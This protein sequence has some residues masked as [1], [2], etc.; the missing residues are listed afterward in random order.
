MQTVR[1]ALMQEGFRQVE[2][3]VGDTPT[4]SLAEEFP[5]VSEIRP[6]NFVFYDLMQWQLGSCTEQDI[7]VAVAVPVVAVYPERRQVVV[8]GGAVH[9]SKESLS[10]PHQPPIFGLAAFP[11]ETG[12]GTLR[13]DFYLQ[14]LSQEHGIVQVPEE[15]LPDIHIGDL[16]LIVPVHSCLTVNLMRHQ[17]G[18]IL[19]I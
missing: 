18:G 8:H 4:C 19:I 10:L 9:F 16:L 6:G 13:Q 3:S 15:L 7:A 5:G 2:I 17:R 11:T 14:S 12:W 1:N